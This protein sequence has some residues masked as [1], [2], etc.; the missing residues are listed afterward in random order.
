MVIHP[1]NEEIDFQCQSIKSLNDN[2]LNSLKEGNVRVSSNHY[3]ALIVM[4]RKSD[5][6]IRVCNDYRAISE[7]MVKDSF[8]LPC[9]DDL[10]D[11]LRDA[12]IITHLNLRSSYNQVRMSDV[13][14]SDDSIVATSFQGLTPNGSPCL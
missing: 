2:L 13:G 10:I 1:D 5:G 11:Q 7:R 6:S 9:I 12:T 4:V 3:A 8:P 14:P